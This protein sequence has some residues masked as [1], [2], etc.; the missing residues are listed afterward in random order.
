VTGLRG[1]EIPG[2]AFYPIEGET[3]I[4]WADQLKSSGIS[5]H[6]ICTGAGAGL[7]QKLW[8][9]PGSSAYLS[10]ASFPY[11]QAE[12]D[13]TLGFVPGSYCSPE[14]AIDLACVAYQRAYSFG[15]KKPVG[16][17]LTASVA[18]ESAHRGEHRV[19]ACLITDEQV[20]SMNQ[21]LVKGVGED[22]R[23]SDGVICDSIGLSLLFQAV[24]IG[25][26]EAVAKHGVEDSS[27][28]ALERFYVHPFFAKNGARTVDVPKD[29]VLMPGAYNPPHPG[30]FGMA[31]EVAKQALKPVVFHVTA[32]GPHKAPL[33]LQDLL[34]R[35][36]MLRGHD[37]LFT[38]GDSL[39]LDKARRFPGVPIAMGAD[40]LARMLDPKWGQPVLPM[41][42]ELSQLKTRF[43]VT[44]RPVD[45]DVL[46]MYKV[47]ERSG[48]RDY[49]LLTQMFY[50]VDGLWD[51]SSTQV[52]AEVLGT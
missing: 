27:A 22:Q 26:R 35:A 10:G 1:P 47:F 19:H 28:K 17:G 43:Y 24:D 42:Y 39:Y 18:S 3:M 44:S 11:R 50:Q 12:T 9:V 5:I 29:V 36:R 40:A 23:L 21:V 41:L 30:H 15:G 32:D 13:K 14:A 16:L 20:V 51:I 38:R 52:R 34:K 4:P 8:E 6:I 7:Q 25:W 46:T 33:T 2:R 48:I 45:G 31:S 37:R 49:D